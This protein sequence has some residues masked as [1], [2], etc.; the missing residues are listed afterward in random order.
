VESG[1]K[2][3]VYGS[4]SVLSLPGRPYTLKN[5]ADGS[6]RI[7]LDGKTEGAAAGVRSHSC[8]VIL[9]LRHIVARHSLIGRHCP[10][11][12][13]HI[14]RTQLNGYHDLLMIVITILINIFWKAWDSADRWPY[15]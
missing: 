1:Y 9:R 2:E 13:C 7:L 11:A 14:S 10:I 3:G 8:F 15:R 4:P 5:K 6:P 12:A